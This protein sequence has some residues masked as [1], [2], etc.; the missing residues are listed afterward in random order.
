M[1]LQSRAQLLDWFSDANSGP[2]PLPLAPLLQR[3]RQPGAIRIVLAE[4]AIP[5]P[6]HLFEPNHVRIIDNANMG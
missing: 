6:F 5:E 4:A 3:R 1:S 2:C